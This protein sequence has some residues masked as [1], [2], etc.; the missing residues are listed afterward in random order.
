[1]T[2]KSFVDTIVLIYAASN[3]PEDQDK[4]LAARA[5]LAQPDIGPG[6]EAALV[7]A[8]GELF[9]ARPTSL[10][11][12]ACVMAGMVQMNWGG[13][14][15][16]DQRCCNKYASFRRPLSDIA[17]PEASHTRH[18]LDLFPRECGL[19]VQ[20]PGAILRGHHGL[21]RQFAF[22]YRRHNRIDCTWSP[23]AS[24]YQ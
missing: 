9:Y 1:M 8:P 14:D 4:R 7:F 17:M 20:F 2:A 19:D 23:V 22:R 5:L 11:G 21:S 16:S 18:E 12:V 3:A 10:S 15:A 6:L 24:M 13:P